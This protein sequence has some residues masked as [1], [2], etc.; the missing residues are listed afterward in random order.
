MILKHARPAAIDCRG[1]LRHAWHCWVVAT[2]PLLVLAMT[3]VAALNFA[4]AAE[5]SPRANT[6]R[7]N[8][9]FIVVDDLNDWIGALGGHRQA[10]TP[11]LDRLLSESVYCSNAHCNAPVCAAS[12]NSML[13]GLRPSTT[14]WYN[15]NHSICGQ[16]W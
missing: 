13:S 1:K 6:S 8:V 15:N 14:G 16:Y 4:Q 5:V 11:N 12:R 2:L 3:G 7:P 9:L 10:I